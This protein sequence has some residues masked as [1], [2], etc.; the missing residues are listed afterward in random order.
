MLNETQMLF[1]PFCISLCCNFE[2]KH[3]TDQQRI[4]SFQEQ[5]KSHSGFFNSFQILLKI[6]SRKKIRMVMK[7]IGK[8]LSGS[9]N[10]NGY[11]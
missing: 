11:I 1:L 2:V 8:E 3:S 7:K 5:Q 9:L 4:L 6:N 10:G